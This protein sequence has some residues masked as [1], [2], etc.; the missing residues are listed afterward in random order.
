LVTER[1]TFE[2]AEEYREALNAAGWVLTS[3]EA[4]GFGTTLSFEQSDSGYAGVANIDQF[5]SDESLNAVTIQVQAT[6]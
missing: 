3:D 4:Q 5:P 2:V 1:S 6:N